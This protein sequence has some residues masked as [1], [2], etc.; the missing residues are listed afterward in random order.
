MVDTCVRAQIFKNNECIFRKFSGNSKE[1]NIDGLIDNLKVMQ[2]QVNDFLTILVE[3]ER[4]IADKG[5]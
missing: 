2:Q 5:E 1:N 3:S 4:L